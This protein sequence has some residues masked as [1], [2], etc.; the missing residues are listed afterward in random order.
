MI[1]LPLMNERRRSVL[2]AVVWAFFV[3]QGAGAVVA[4]V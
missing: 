4:N 2:E 1:H 3:G